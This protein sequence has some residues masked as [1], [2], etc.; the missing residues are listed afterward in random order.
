MS[1]KVSGLIMESMDEVF[2]TSTILTKWEWFR[3]LRE[4]YLFAVLCRF[5]VR[6]LVFYNLHVFGR[7]GEILIYK[8]D[9]ASQL[10]NRMKMYDPFCSDCGN[11]ILLPQPYDRWDGR[12]SKVLMRMNGFY[13]VLL[14][15]NCEHS[16]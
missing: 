11:R 9:E 13:F 3:I 1:F 7:V 4:R 12:Y 5:D 6:Q 15:I 10:K 16:I 8:K 14:C 2:D